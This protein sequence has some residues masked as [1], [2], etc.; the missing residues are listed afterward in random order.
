MTPR[1]VLPISH[2]MQGTNALACTPLARGQRQG[3][4]SMGCHPH[5]SGCEWCPP[6]VCTVVALAEGLEHCLFSW[7][8]QV[9]PF[10]ALCREK[11][12]LHIHTHIH[13]HAMSFQPQGQ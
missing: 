8:K 4:R 5:T 10:L 1:L 9:L 6:H 11:S 12:H 3:H 13:I 7:V 2:N